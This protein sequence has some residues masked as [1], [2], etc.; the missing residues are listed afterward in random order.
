MSRETGFQFYG[1]EYI[2]AVKHDLQLD[3]KVMLQV[4]R[5]QSIST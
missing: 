1:R 4:H 3:L 2:A 5:I